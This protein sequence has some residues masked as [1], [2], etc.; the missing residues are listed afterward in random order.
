MIQAPVREDQRYE[1]VIEYSGTP[2]PVDVPTQRSDFGETGFTIT[3][4]H[5]V[6]TMQE[7]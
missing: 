4:D 5:E 1:V 3:D 2:E 7:P 6:W